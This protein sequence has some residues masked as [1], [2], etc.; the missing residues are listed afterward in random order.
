MKNL[1]RIRYGENGV[2][3]NYQKDLQIERFTDE[4]DINHMPAL[5]R[6]AAGHS[7]CKNAYLRLLQW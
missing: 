4:T 1:F 5:R 7:K 2:S 6:K 3:F